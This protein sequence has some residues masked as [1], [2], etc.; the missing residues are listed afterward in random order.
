MTLSQKF[1]LLA[2][3]GLAPIALGYGFLPELRLPWLYDV[4]VSSP[5]GKHIYRAVMGLYFGMCVLWL[6]GAF[7]RDMT[8]P[9]L[10]SLVVFMLGL[11]GGRVLSLLIDGM[12]GGLVVLYLFLELVFGAAG[13]WFL[14]KEADQN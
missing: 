14:Q 6:L 13:L 2:A 9:A 8:R 10:W 7:K 3:I 1:L 11:A 4:E 5:N 12:A